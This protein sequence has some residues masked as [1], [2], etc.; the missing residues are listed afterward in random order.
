MSRRRHSH[1]VVKFVLMTL[2]LV[3]LIQ[4]EQRPFANPD[5]VLKP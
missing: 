4:D 3:G 1:S 2:L 5:V